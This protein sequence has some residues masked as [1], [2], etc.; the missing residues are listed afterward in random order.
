[1]RPLALVFILAAAVSADPLR[2]SMSTGDEASYAASFKSE[3]IVR[4]GSTVERFV[5]TR[6]G[7]QKAT[8]CASENGRTL[9]SVQTDHGPA[10]PV[11]YTVDGQDR[12]KAEGERLMAMLPGASTDVSFLWLDD[13]GSGAPAPRDPSLEEAVLRALDEIEVLPDADEKSWER[14]GTV[15]ALSWKGAFTRVAATVSA[16]FTFSSP[17]Q[18]GA[19]VAFEPARGSITMLAGCARSIEGSAAWTVATKDGTERR[20]IRFNLTGSAGTALKPA[21]ASDSASDAAPMI[22]AQ[23]AWRDG[24]R[25]RA[26]ELWEKAGADAANRWG[27]FARL[28]AI[29]V[30]RDWPMLGKA[31]PALKAT[32]WIGPAPEAGK[33]QLVY[34]WATWAPR[35]E[36]ELSAIAGLLKGRSRVAGAAVT[37]AD[38]LQSE[39]EIRRM[40]SKV[41]LPFGVAMEDGELSKGFKVE[42]LPRVFL[43]DPE[44]KVRFEGRGSE[45][46]TLKVVMDRLAGE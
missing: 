33:W 25:D 15:G 37:R 21:E 26:V 31:A 17:E 3:T 1:M 39:D 30:R 7:T 10:R 46:E 12:M 9:F 32:S 8:A 11:S 14:S 43:V 38:T 22:A 20:E 41:A 4:R 35:C 24:E 13:R 34:F 36:G 16:V 6:A 23:E 27:S 45:V 5:W 19:R 44:G 18:G 42:D 2:Y 29:E 40:A 28:R